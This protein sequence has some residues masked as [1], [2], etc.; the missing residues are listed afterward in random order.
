MNTLY[1]K[2]KNLIIYFL[3]QEIIRFLIAG[4]INTI[5]G[6]IAIPYLVLQIFT[7]NSD[8]AKTFIPL[9]VGYIIWF[10]F[11]YLIQVYFVFRTQF[12][13]KRFFLYPTTQI[14]NYLINQG[15]LYIFNDLLDLHELISLILAALIAAPIMFVLVRLVVKKSQKKLL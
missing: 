11:A 9:I 5:I 13:I 10:P 12:D 4:G 6:G 1:E 15:L 7:F 8:I 3:K 14:P 2:I